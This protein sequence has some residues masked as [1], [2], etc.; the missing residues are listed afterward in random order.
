MS[1]GQQ[2]GHVKKS[3]AVVW[4]ADIQNRLGADV[5]IKVKSTLPENLAWMAAS[6]FILDA[7]I[8]FK[9]GR[10]LPSELLTD[11]NSV[12]KDA[13]IRSN[14]S[15]RGFRGPVSP[16]GRR[17]GK[18]RSDQLV[19]AEMLRGAAICCEMLRDAAFGG[20]SSARRTGS[21]STG[22]VVCPNQD[23][24]GQSSTE[25]NRV[26]DPPSPPNYM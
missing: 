10:A 26:V 22:P 11:S 24:L 1:V 23:S 25:G 7:A 13:A 4:N 6:E 8:R 3:G 16:G 17:Q 2:G 14:F 15:G 18:I 21:S 5:A 20:T 19:G 9:L 12:A